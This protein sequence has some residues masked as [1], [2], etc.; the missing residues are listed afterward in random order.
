MERPEPKLPKPTRP[1]PGEGSESNLAP[2]PVVPEQVSLEALQ[3]QALIAD[4]LPEVSTDELP[5]LLPRKIRNIAEPESLDDRAFERR[6]EAIRRE[7]EATYGS[8]EKLAVDTD[9]WLR[10]MGFD[11]QGNPLKKEDV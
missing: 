9:A 4:A 5:G 2:G 6:Q 11:E 3:E 7:R 10:S 8:D 1:N